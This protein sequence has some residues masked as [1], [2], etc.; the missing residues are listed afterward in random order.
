[1]K[2]V[3]GLGTNLGE[4]EKY[5]EKAIL[6]LENFATTTK[7]S[8]IY[9]TEPVGLKNQ[10]SFLNQVI[11]VECDLM[12]LELIFKTQEIEHKMGR[13]R[14]VKNGPRT[15]DIDILFQEQTVLKNKGLIIPHKEVHKR[16]FTLIP[17]NE[18]L[19]DL[20]HPILN[21]TIKQLKEELKSTK[22]VKK[23][24]KQ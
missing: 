22:Q 12:P 20:I 10:P 9:E 14:E 21:K 16:N 17:I 1:M 19:P 7:K 24:K 11:E 6:Y 3:I 18:I 15:I 5:L 13:V 4:R 2:Y 8:S 23:W